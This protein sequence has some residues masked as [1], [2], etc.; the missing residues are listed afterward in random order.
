MI[1]AIILSIALLGQNFTAQHLPRKI[2]N[3]LPPSRVDTATG[4]MYYYS[5]D[6]FGQ[7]WAHEDIKHLQ[8]FVKERNLVPWAAKDKFDRQWIHQ[9]KKVLLDFIRK[10]NEG[11]Q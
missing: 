2:Q 10:I 5:T 4:K 11:T 6:K 8:K 1:T 7:R 3:D 9:D